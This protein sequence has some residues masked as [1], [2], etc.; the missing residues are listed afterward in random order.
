[1]AKEQYKMLLGEPCRCY[2]KQA[3]G[4][5]QFNQVAYYVGSGCAVSSFTDVCDKL[6]YVILRFDR[7]IPTRLWNSDYLHE[8]KTKSYTNLKQILLPD[9]EVEDFNTERLIDFYQGHLDEFW[10]WKEIQ[11]KVGDTLYRE[12]GFE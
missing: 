5:Y 9:Y 1:M 7:Y 11:T 8:L 4:S 3:D 10:W 2:H 6:P 12:V